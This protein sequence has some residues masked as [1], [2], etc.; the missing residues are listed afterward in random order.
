MDVVK[1]CI[2]DV[3]FGGEGRKKKKRKKVGWRAIRQNRTRY[4]EQWKKQIKETS[5]RRELSDWYY[6]D[7]KR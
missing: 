7:F 1:K 6:I 3:K 2:E 4:E 5:S